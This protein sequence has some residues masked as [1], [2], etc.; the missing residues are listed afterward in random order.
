MRFGDAFGN[1]KADAEAAGRGGVGGIGPVEVVKQAVKRPVRRL[2]AFV[3]HCKPDAAP[4]R[5]KRDSNFGIRRC[6]LHGIIEQDRH[7][8]P[9]SGLVAAEGA[10]RR[11]ENLY[12]AALCLRKGFKG[13]RRILHGLADGERLR[14][15][16]RRL[17][18]VF[19]ER[20]ERLHQLAQLLVTVKENGL[21]L[22]V[23]LRSHKEFAAGGIEHPR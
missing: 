4:E 19:A 23:F 12:C 22:P 18:A 21:I 7:E 17:F 16:Q 20:D 10:L 8:L 14:V 13:F 3:F 15:Q 5:L 2:G 11:G 1:G 6:V 9:H